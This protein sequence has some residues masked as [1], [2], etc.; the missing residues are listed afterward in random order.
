MVAQNG[1][2]LPNNSG[3]LWLSKQPQLARVVFHNQLFFELNGDLIAERKLHERALHLAC[4]NSQIFRNSCAS[5]Q[6]FLNLNMFLRLFANSDHVTSLELTRRRE[7]ADAVNG[8]M[9]VSDILTSSKDGASEAHAEHCCV[10]AGFEQDYQ[11]ITCRT[12]ATVCFGISL[13][14]LSF[15]NV[16]G[17][18]KT[19]LFD[20]LLLIHRSGLLAVLTMLARCKMTTVESLLSLLRNSKVQGTGN[21]ALRSTERGHINLVK[22]SSLVHTYTGRA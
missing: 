7:A 2:K 8:E 19:L 10:Q 12:G 14:K 6:C 17:E 4:I 5:G 11:V 18:A 13:S 3:L 16:V 21:L 1:L 20:E 15:G 22:G 9:T